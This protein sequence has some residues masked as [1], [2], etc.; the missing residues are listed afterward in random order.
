MKT[1]GANEGLTLRA[2]QGDAAA[3]LAFDND[4]SQRED[5]AGFALEYT[6]PEGDT[7]QVGNRLNF[8]DPVVAETTPEER[9]AIWTDTREAPL[10]K[11]QW[12]HYPPEVSSG[13]FAYNATAMLFKPGTEVEIEPGPSASVQITLEPPTFPHFKLGF[14]RGYLSSQAYH[15]RFH[16][17]PIVP[18]HQTID[19][20]TKP[21]EDQYQWL[22]LDAR[23]LVFEFLDEARGDDGIQLD[24]FAYDLNEPDF[25]RGLE[26]LGTRL[27]LFLDDSDSH[28]KPHADGTLPFELQAKALLQQ[29]AGEGNVKTGKFQR[30]SHSKVMIQRRGDTAVK[31][32]GGSANFSVRGLYVQSNNVFVFEDKETAGLYEEAFKQAWEHPL[33]EFDTS[34]IA[35]QWFT[36]S[37]EGMPPFA[38]SFSPHKDASVSLDRI[39]DAI[40]GAESSVLFAVMEIGAASG[41]VADALRDLPGRDL[42]AFGTTQR[43]DG[44]LKVTSPADPNSPFIPFDYLKSKVPP[45]FNA[46]IGGGAGQVI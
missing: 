21:F 33:S 6:T 9:R 15:D 29:S 2:Y 40:L 30:F 16:N 13:E 43:L 4:E 5:L 10:Q 41:R 1:T 42:Y 25:V 20:D 35:S 17:A 18:D 11:F 23:K 27:R 36:P 28:V 31:V 46:E 24:V 26:K 45:P 7:H 14:T 8:S 34:D 3:L 39:A 32:L 38:V 44:S 19:Y 12:V 22:G 37:G